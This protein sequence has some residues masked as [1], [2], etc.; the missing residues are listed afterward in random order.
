M[1]KTKICGLS[2]PEAVE[3]ALAG[4]AAY[5]GF[6]FFPASPR[7]V[8]P[9][10]AAQLAA[11]ARGKAKIVAVMVDPDWPLIEAVAVALEP[12]FVQLH[13]DDFVLL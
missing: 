4:G 2:T 3:A 12:D 1:T 9:Q 13:L 10:Q 5:L 7:Y 11:P 8:T 6:N